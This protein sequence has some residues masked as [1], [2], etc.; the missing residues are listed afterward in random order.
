MARRSRPALA[1]LLAGAL[2]MV[3]ATPDIDMAP[4]DRPGLYRRFAIEFV[5]EGDS[6]RLLRDG[7]PIPD[8]TLASLPGEEEL[9]EALRVRETW[10]TFWRLGGGL[11]LLPLGTLVGVDNFFG[12]RKTETKLGAI[13]LPP[14]TFVPQHAGPDSALTGLLLGSGALLAGWGLGLLVEQ[15]AIWAGWT[16]P[17]LLEPERAA[18]AAE[19]QR[20]ALLERLNLTAPPLAPSPTPAPDPSATPALPES[21]LDPSFPEGTEGSAAWAVRQALRGAGPGAWE[22]FLAWTD[23]M[24]NLEGGVLTR[25]DWQVMVRRRSAVPDPAVPYGLLPEVA[26]AMAAPSD[27]VREV[28]VPRFG[29]ALSWRSGALP[30][31]VYRT[32][33]TAFRRVRIDSPEALPRLLATMREAGRSSW[34][35]PGTRVILQPFRGRMAEPM[36]LILPPDEAPWAALDA[37]RGNLI[38]LPGRP[39]TGTGPTSPGLAPGDPPGPAD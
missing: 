3:P 1:G 22:P 8:R 19:R 17:R 23:D 30:Y 31:R 21:V 27:D 37:D 14:S 10:G 39:R 18:A 15:T 2:T 6:Y 36:W 26:G 38:S 11:L 34:W 25:G 33:T 29:G 35:R 13:T 9:A 28:R 5:P 20:E 16:M 4:D 12:Y 24:D 7:Q 32:G